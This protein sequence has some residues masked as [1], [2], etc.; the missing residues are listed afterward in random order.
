MS[1]SE[2]CDG[3]AGGISRESGPFLHPI[4]STD[5]SVFISGGR[6]GNVLAITLETALGILIQ[7]SLGRRKK[8]FPKI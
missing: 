7:Y 3:L 8:K 5:Y 2:W 4:S 1:G 6:S